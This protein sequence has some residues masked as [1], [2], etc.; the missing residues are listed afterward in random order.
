MLRKIYLILSLLLTVGSVSVFANVFLNPGFENPPPPNSSPAV[1]FIPDTGAFGWKTTHPLGA[2]CGLGPLCRPIEFWSNGQGGIPPAQGVQFVELNAY[3]LSMLFQQVALTTGDTLNWSFLHR[4]RLSSS[5]FEVVDF[6][7]GIPVFPPGGSLPPDSYGFSIAKV[8]T[9]SSGANV[10][11]SSSGTITVTPVGNGW[12]RYSGSYVYTGATQTVN[13]G[14]SSA[15]NLNTNPRES[16]GNFIDDANLEINGCC[17]Q[18]KVTPFWEPNVA[19]DY[20]TFEIYNL[21][22]PS[23][24]ICSIDIDIRN[25]PNNQQ[26]PSGWQG[27]EL[28]V[29]GLF[30]SIPQWWRLP[31]N[32]IPNGTNGATVIDGHPGISASAVRFNLGIDYSTPYTGTVTLIIKHCD[33][34]ICRLTFPN[35][36]PQPP[37]RSGIIA[38]EAFRNGF[39]Q[40]FAAVTTRFQTLRAAKGFVKWIVVEALDEDAEISSADAKS[41]NKNPVEDTDASA[42]KN[43]LNAASTAIRRKVALYELSQPVSLEKAIGGELN[44]V[45]KRGGKL[46]VKPGLKYIFFDESANPIGFTTSEEGK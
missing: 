24:D 28:F 20:K 30:R 18:M 10:I 8:A 3:K 35:W 37:M 5:T 44:L 25:S 9:T 32:R 23:S 38:N 2:F 19:I 40:E 43:S 39:E 31:Y 42:E 27:G 46:S 34:L 12:V 21:K 33:G 41:S 22:S 45:I 29:N 15:G 4:G 26:P 11:V 13:I 1:R 36:T 16:I 14:F 17:D 6:R 7:I